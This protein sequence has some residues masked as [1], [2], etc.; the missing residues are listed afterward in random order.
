MIAEDYET[1]ITA[2]YL[3]GTW[4]KTMTSIDDVPQQPIGWPMTMCFN[5]NGTYTA[6]NT[7]PYEEAGTWEIIGA[8]NDTSLALHMSSNSYGAPPS[9]WQ[10]LARRIRSWDRFVVA[11]E[12]SISETEHVWVRDYYTRQPE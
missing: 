3:V 11:Y 10:G 6:H 7:T 4:E 1:P 2:E 8:D 9:D 5:A 12:D